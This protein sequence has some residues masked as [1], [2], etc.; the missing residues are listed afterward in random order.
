MRE[1]VGV[2]QL[3]VAHKCTHTHKVATVRCSTELWHM[4]GKKED[5]VKH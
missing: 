2:K 1:S 4:K 3:T 5:R